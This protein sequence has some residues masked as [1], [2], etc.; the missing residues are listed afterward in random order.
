M[1]SAFVCPAVVLPP[2]PTCRGAGRAAN[3]E[4]NCD[5]FLA[6]SARKKRHKQEGTRELEK[7]KKEKSNEI[8]TDESVRGGNIDRH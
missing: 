7:R 3:V 2:P 6:C 8:E 5:A 4:T 1:T